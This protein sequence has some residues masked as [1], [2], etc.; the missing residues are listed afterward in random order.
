[1]A[2]Y[3]DA[4]CRLCRREGMKLFLKGERCFTPKCSIQRRNQP[5]GMHPWNRGSK[6]DY[7]KQ[8]REKQKAKRYYGILDSQFKK[9][10]KEAE[11]LKGD[12]GQNLL[13]LLERRLDNVVRRLGFGVSIAQARQLVVHRHIMVNGKIVDR[14]SYQ[15]KQGDI[16]APSS[17]ESSQKLVKE[18]LEL[19]QGLEMPTW[20]NLDAESLQGT[21]VEMPIRDEIPIE[22][23]EQLIVEFSSR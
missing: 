4:V 21:V 5:P 12:T 7:G 11:R 8:L 13:I 19:G 18:N 14:P 9:Y 17:K 3:R 2:R 15:V 1:M 6:K 10:F 20:L 23:H 16:I 22:I